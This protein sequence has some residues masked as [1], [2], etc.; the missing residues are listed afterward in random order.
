VIAGLTREDSRSEVRK[1]PVLGSIPIIGLL[2]RQTVDQTEKRNML[3]F[4][5]PHIV[6]GM[7]H[8]EEV[9]NHWKEKTGLSPNEDD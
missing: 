5:T 7:A 2:F 8:A 4:V 3:I 6:T 9:M 1:F